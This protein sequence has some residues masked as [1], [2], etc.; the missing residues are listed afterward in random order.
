MKNWVIAAL[1]MS[2]V[3]FADVDEVDNK[4]THVV[5]CRKDATVRVSGNSNTFTLKGSCK[6]VQISGN[7]N[8]VNGDGAKSVLLSGN[9]NTVALT[10]IGNVLVSG[11]KNSISYKGKKPHVADQ[12]NGNR[13]IQ[14]K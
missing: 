10:T 12:G 14:A 5:D 13:I 4:Q 1:L 6:S 7:S 2:S 8:T 9:E 11:D 3:A